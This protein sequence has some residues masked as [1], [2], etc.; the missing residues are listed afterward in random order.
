[1]AGSGAAIGAVVCALAAEHANHKAAA[2]MTGRRGEVP[3]MREL[4]TVDPGIAS[5]QPLA[6]LRSQC[7]TRDHRVICALNG[8]RGIVNPRGRA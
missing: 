7:A 5:P 2:T 6:L 1:M 4:S 3:I 8:P